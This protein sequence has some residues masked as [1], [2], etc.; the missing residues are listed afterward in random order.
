MS[1]RDHVLVRVRRLLVCT[2]V[3]VAMAGT[4]YLCAWYHMRDAMG[5]RWNHQQAFY[6]LRTLK[7]ALDDYGKEKRKYPEKLADLKSTHADDLWIDESGQVLDPW[8]NP[9]EYRAEGNSYT[10]FSLGRDGKRG[11]EGLDQDLDVRDLRSNDD[12]THRI[13]VVGIPTLWQFTFE[14]GNDG[15]MLTCGLAGICAFVI[16]LDSRRTE[17]PIKLAMTLVACFVTAVVISSIHIPNHH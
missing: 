11:G 12:G 5:Y 3:G 9:F 2:A 13:P 17:R 6:K 7:T 15:V 16:C 8:G 14:P 1:V 10:L 4:A